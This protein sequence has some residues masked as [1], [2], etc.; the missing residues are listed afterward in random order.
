MLP[1]KSTLRAL[2]PIFDEK[3]HILRVGGRLANSSRYHV[4]FKFSI[5]VPCRSIINAALIRETHLHCLHEGLQ[6]TLSTLRQTVWIPNVTRPIQSII[7]KCPQC[8]RFNNRQRQPQMGTHRQ[9]VF[10]LQH[11][12]ATLDWTI[13]AQ[14][15]RKQ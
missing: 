6:L 14:S 12:S 8:T 13:A 3:K 2:A 11:I 10:P 15:Q 9:N 4:D 7:R 1:R 5:I